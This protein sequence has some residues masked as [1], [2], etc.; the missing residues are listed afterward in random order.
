MWGFNKKGP[1]KDGALQQALNEAFYPDEMSP[2]YTPSDLGTPDATPATATA[3]TAPQPEPDMPAFTRSVSGFVPL[4]AD[5]DTIRASVISPVISLQASPSSVASA[6]SSLESSA[7]MH[8]ATDLPVYA[9]SSLD[10]VVAAGTASPLNTTQPPSHEIDYTQNVR[11]L[12][13]LVND[14]PEGVSKPMGAQVIRLTM[15]AM[16][17]SLE[18]VLSEAQGAQTEM[19][20]AVRK[21]LSRIEELRSVITQLESDIKHYQFRSGELAD[22]IDLFI[23]GDAPQGE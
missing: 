4:G 7:A 5:D 9:E 2:L 18:D 19:L 20:D 3:L 17:A 21:N 1:N 13:R 23:L 8:T 16:G 12:M 6:R 22:M 15:E 11:T 10:S 14:L